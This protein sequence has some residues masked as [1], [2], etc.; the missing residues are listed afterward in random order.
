MRVLLTFLTA[1]LLSGH[2]MAQSQ[3]KC[4][5]LNVWNEEEPTVY[6]KS[7]FKGMLDS[8]KNSGVRCV[9]GQPDGTW[10]RAANGQDILMLGAGGTQVVF[11]LEGANN[12]SATGGYINALDDDDNPDGQWRTTAPPPS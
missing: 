6:V 4:L 11:I 1:I 12:T 7:T 10:E 3:D 9:N 2:A 5:W 8:S